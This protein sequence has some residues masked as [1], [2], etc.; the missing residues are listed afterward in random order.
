MHRS[1]AAAAPALLSLFLCGAA[2]LGA[3]DLPPALAERLSAERRLLSFS[4]RPEGLS[5]LPEFSGAVA[6]RERHAALAPHVT[7][8]ALFALPKDYGMLERADVAALLAAVPSVSGLSWPDEKTGKR[9]V[10][11]R[12]AEIVGAPSVLD[13]GMTLILKTEDADFGTA[14]FEVTVKREADRIELRMVN[15]DSLHFLVFPSVRPG[16]AI[17]DLIYFPRSPEPLIYLAWSVR[18]V[19]FVPGAVDVERPLRNRALA[20]ADWY[21]KQLEVLHK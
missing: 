1:G 17:V 6:F 7:Q 19:L 5:L 12:S 20:L 18:A 16:K 21:V 9:R 10:L 13:D 11:F 3:Q 15:L 14:R 8:E 2:A 4:V